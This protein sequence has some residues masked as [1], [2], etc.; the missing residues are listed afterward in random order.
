MRSLSLSVRIAGL[1]TG[2]LLLPLATAR[3]QKL[4]QPWAD[5]EDQPPRVDL[6]ASIGVLMPTQWSSLVLLGS[7]SSASGLLEQVLARELV[8]EPDKNYG[9]AVTYWVG[10]YGFRVQGDYS[11][12]SV[13]IGGAPLAGL[14]V[15]GIPMIV[16]LKTWLYDARGV[17]GFLEY[18][19]ARKVWPY[20]FIGL[21]GI[22]YLLDRTVGPPLTAVTV[23]PGA[24]SLRDII[25]RDQGRQFIL[26]EEELGRKTVFALSAGVGT[27]LRIPFGPAGIGLRL[28][29]SDRLASSPLTLSI[30]ELGLTGALV[31][32]VPVR[33]GVVH[34]LN[35][36]AGVVL[37]FGR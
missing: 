16:P 5:P 32:D 9:A 13:R 7:I 23:A 8:V 34:H 19:P 21:G 24:P 26:S 28:E 15:S 35:A 3:A 30:R 29:V 36:S 18:A 10:R 2:V 27:D 4:P 22:S 25:I 20:G 11:K 17:I 12:S 37:H 14:D 33:F 1:V 31:G 6:S